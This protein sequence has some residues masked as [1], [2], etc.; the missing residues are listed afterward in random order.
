MKMPR[1]R[2]S[3]TKKGLYLSSSGFLS[4]YFA[5]I[6]SSALRVRQR[7]RLSDEESSRHGHAAR[8]RAGGDICG[9]HTT[10]AGC[11]ADLGHHCAWV[12]DRCEPDACMT[13]PQ[14]HL[15]LTVTPDVCATRRGCHWTGRFCVMDSCSR[16]EYRGPCDDEAHCQW[17]RDAEVCTQD[18]YARG[19]SCDGKPI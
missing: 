12:A 1:R 8:E 18:P 11:E 7:L 14:P 13:P 17:D 4:I 19:S 2:S 5:G 16:H 15:H 9:I 6:Y 10:T 3:S